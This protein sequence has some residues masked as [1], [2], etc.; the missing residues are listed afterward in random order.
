[1]KKIL[2]GVLLLQLN[3]CVLYDA[4]F[5]AKYDTNEYGLATKIKTIAETLEC[6]NEDTI[7]EDAKDMWIYSIELKNFTQ[8]LP[9][10]EKSHEMASKLTD[11]TLGLHNKHGKMSKVYC[12]EKIKIIVKTT[13]DIQRTLGGKPR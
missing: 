3:G 9:R 10:N 6:G 7:A 11:I 2:L 12:E 5:A 4:Y 1:M 8:Y 13:D